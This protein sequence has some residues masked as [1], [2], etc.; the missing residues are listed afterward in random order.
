MI[1]YKLKIDCTEPRHLVSDM[2]FVSG[3]VG[4]YLLEFSFYNGKKRMDISDKVLSVK[5]KRTDGVVISDS[6]E[7]KENKAYFIPANTL[8]SVPGELT[9]E[10]ALSD[11]AKNYITTTILSAKVLEGIGAPDAAAENK[12]SVYVTLLAQTTEKIEQA[13][14][15]LADANA[16]LE[17]VEKE[18]EESLGDIKTAILEIEA[19][20]DGLIGGSEA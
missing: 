7:I 19:I 12:V 20:A 9:M 6:G 1:T 17:S 16:H 15:L 8:Y 3:D 14:A 18:R 4:A 10:I 13:K 5:A 11:H 2:E